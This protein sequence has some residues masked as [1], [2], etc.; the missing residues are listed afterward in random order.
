MSAGRRAGPPGARAWLLALAL[1]LAPPLAAEAPP[2]GRLFTTPEE[3]ALLD[4]LR[5]Q[6][7]LPAPPPAQVMATPAAP[8]PPPPAPRGSLTLDGYVIRGDGG[9]TVWVNRESS[10][11][12]AL[13]GA[14]AVVEP[15]RR[16]GA[17]VRVEA[18][19]GTSALLRP[20]QTLPAGEARVQEGYLLPAPA[21]AA[22]GRSPA[23]AGATDPRPGAAPGQ[24]R[25]GGRP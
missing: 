20:G 3:R 22:S 4:E 6:A 13:L 19:D 18:A 15:P 2:L 7:R 12:G 25:T 10:T 17:G 16:A 5:R 21:P 11:G 8:P 1:G 9:R 23:P 24:A 14:E